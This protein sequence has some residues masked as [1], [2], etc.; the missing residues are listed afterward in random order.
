M[1][2]LNSLFVNIFNKKVGQ[3]LYGNKFYESKDTDYLGKKRRY[4]IYNGKEEPSKVPPLWHAWLH[5]L[6]DN[7]PKEESNFAWQKLHKPNLTGTKLAFNPGIDDQ[8]E[9]KFK[10]KYNKWQP[11]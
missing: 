4:V 9:M 6:S 11:K 1:S 2:F 5:Y 10:N 3:D 8:K 7:I